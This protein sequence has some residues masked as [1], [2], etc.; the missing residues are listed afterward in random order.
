MIRIIKNKSIDGKKRINN[1]LAYK[2]RLLFFCFVVLIPFYGSAQTPAQLFKAGTESLNKG[3]FYAASKYLKQSLEKDDEQAEVWFNYAEASRQFNDYTNA[4]KG[5]EECIKRDKEKTF[6]LALFWQGVMQQSN[7][8]YDAAKETLTEFKTRY[9]KKDFYAFK[10][11]Q[12]IESCAWALANQTVNDSVEVIHE[13]DSI[14]TTFSE[15]NPIISDEGLYFSF[16]KTASGRVFRT[17]IYNAAT[18]DIFMPGM[19]EASAKHIANGSFSNHKTYGKEIFFTQCGIENG[20]SRCEIFVSKF[21]NNKWQGAKPLPVNVNLPGHTATHPSVAID[22]AGNQWLIFAANRP[23]G[24]GKMDIWLS[25]RQA[26]FEWDYPRN[27]GAAI[28]TIDDEVTPC[29]FQT[30]KALYF[31]SN[32]HYGF[33]GFDVFTTHVNSISSASFEKPKNL[34]LPI[35]SSANDLYYVMNDSV[36]YFSS[37]RKGSKFIE[38]ETCCNDIYRI[39]ARRKIIDVRDTVSEELPVASNELRENQNEN[40]KEDIVETQ[41]THNPSLT[42]HH[43]I[44]SLTNFNLPIQLYF[45]NDQ[46]DEKTMRDTTALSYVDAY[47]SYISLTNEYEAEF[48]RGLKTNEKSAAQKH[49]QSWFADTVE[50]NFRQLIHFSTLLFNEL[51]QGKKVSITITGYCSPLNFNEYNLHLG[52]RRVSSLL[53]FFFAYRE[54]ALLP[55]FNEGKL[56]FERV[57]AGED[58]TAESVSDRL[59]DV[60]NSVYSPDAARERRVEILKVT[61][62]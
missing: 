16:T 29:F 50:Y 49:L 27:A 43:S 55:Y 25:K 12:L 31:S 33:G 22:E 15:I 45:H 48:L 39:D 54:A 1:A 61:V 13:S 38:A 26:K 20:N 42:T 14:N 18:N 6:P 21:E 40:G 44:S 28:N 56:L 58:K 3:E 62:E 17:R 59:D 57:S 32:W 60:R 23:G 51:Q 46:P 24:K 34:G 41:N 7:G 4:A 36:A 8:E 37:N 11:Q 52:N 10:V 35:N 9:R 2:S 47:Q 5:Y 19:D 53:N 30:E